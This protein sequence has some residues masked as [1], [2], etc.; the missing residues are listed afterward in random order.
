[1]ITCYLKYRIDPYKTQEFEN[2]AKMWIPLV[3]RFGGKHHGYFLP[4]EGANDVA[5]ALFSFKDLAEYERYREKTK[6]DED[7]L[8]A[9]AYA[10]QTRCIINYERSFMKPLFG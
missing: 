2:Y 8:K 10:E 9:F 7:C 3:N 6:T 1:M 5:Y 4:H